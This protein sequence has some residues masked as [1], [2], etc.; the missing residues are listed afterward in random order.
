MVTDAC[1]TNQLRVGQGS[2]GLS[3]C[4]AFYELDWVRELAGNIFHPGG[5]ALTHRT[6]ASMHLPDNG[7]ITIIG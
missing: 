1:Q 4:S 6:L 5:V 7:H 2:Q 3:C